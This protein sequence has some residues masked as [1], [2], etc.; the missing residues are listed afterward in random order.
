MAF[1]RLI[2]YNQALKK[3]NQYSH[4]VISKVAQILEKEIARMSNFRLTFYTIYAL[5]LTEE[6]TFLLV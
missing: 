4:W 6:M 2:K 5:K 3:L 1:A